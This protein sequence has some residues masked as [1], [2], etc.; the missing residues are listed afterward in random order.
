M[1]CMPGPPV[2]N[3][4]LQQIIRGEIERRIGRCSNQGGGQALEQARC[5]LRPDD[6]EQRVCD[7]CWHRTSIVR[8]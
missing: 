1:V 8:E 4:I 5:A 6:G 2:A 3:P 7:A